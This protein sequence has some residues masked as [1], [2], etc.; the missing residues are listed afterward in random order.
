MDDKGKK[1][2]CSAPQ[3]IDYI[4]TYINKN[5]NDHSIFPTKHGKVS[6]FSSYS[7]CLLLPA[8]I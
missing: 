2:K 7:A 6:S 1:S 5:V 4:T 3:Y 8:Y